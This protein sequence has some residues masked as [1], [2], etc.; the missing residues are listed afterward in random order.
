MFFLQ[1]MNPA[2]GL[3]ADTCR[4]NSPVS[5]AVVG[6]ALSSYPVAVERGWLARAD[7]VERSLAAL[8]F[9]RDSDQS[10]SPEATGYKGFYY[11]FLDM[12]TGAR[13]WRSE[14]SMI[15]TALL[16]AGV[17]TAGRYFT[18]DTADESELRELGDAL[19]R[20]I[21]SEERRV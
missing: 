3:V 9:F 4:E 13:V 18:A 7:A 19:Y 10:G 6:F 14:L 8:R 17:L 5:I 20:R 11:H 12:A 15:D 16:I 1:T 21:R 2:N